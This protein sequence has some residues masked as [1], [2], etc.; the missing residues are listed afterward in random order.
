M[1]AL[2]FMGD[3]HIP[4]RA[5][6]VPPQ[7]L[8][9]IEE[10]EPYDA[11]FFTGDLESGEVLEWVNSIKAR[12]HCIVEGNMDYLPLPQFCI[13]EL[14]DCKIG[15]IHGHQVYPRGDK[16]R[17]G[18]L[19]SRLDVD[20]LVNGHTHSP[21]VEARVINGKSILLLNPGS[22]TGVWSG[23]GGSLIPSMMIGV[24]EARSLKLDH[25]ELY[26]GS[27]RRRIFNIEL[28]CT[29]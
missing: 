13:V 3:T 7:F 29:S 25:F 4:T 28:P 10:N 12:K 21:F 9:V 1:Y 11:I 22:L 8:K 18:V 19:A 16:K 2:L 6:R 23:G 15:V 20:V 26:K 5:R 14:G 24:L 17:L 27:L